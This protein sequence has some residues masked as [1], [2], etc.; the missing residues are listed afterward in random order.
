[1]N[2][3]EEKIITPKPELP[4]LAKLYRSLEELQMDV[5]AWLKK[6]NEYCPHSGKWCF[7]K[8]PMQTF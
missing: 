4:A 6:Y 8:T 7:G 2:T 3:V 5:N 1:M